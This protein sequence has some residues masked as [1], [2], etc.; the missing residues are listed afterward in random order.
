MGKSDL[1]IE[2][3]PPVATV[4]LNRPE[5]RN[6]MHIGMIRELTS[7]LG[8][9]EKQQDIRILCLNAAGPDFCSGADLHWMREGMD[10]SEATLRSESLELAGLFRD[11]ASSRLIIIASVHGRV[12]GGAIGLVAAADL[13]VAE[14]GSSFA[15]SEVRLG[16]VPATI[17]PYAIGK[18]GFSRA[19]ELMLS[20]RVFTAE[21]AMQ[22]GL[23]HSLCLSGELE[24]ATGQRV[25]QLLHNG[26][27]AMSGTKSLL[28]R[29]NRQPVGEELMELTAALIARHRISEE[30]QEGMRAFFEKRKPSWDETK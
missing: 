1:N 8:H 4:T 23:V 24:T 14:S 19:K 26:P 17:A 9:L 6:A 30:G 21:A 7:T 22:Y 11:L 28:N 2:L 13:A 18:L 29:L 27:E 20:G 25:A 10:Q 3:V 12:M 5:V 16:L 15:F